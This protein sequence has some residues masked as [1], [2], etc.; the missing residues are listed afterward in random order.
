MLQALLWMVVTVV[1]G[2]GLHSLAYFV[3]HRRSEKVAPPNVSGRVVMYGLF[4]VIGMGFGLFGWNIAVS[5][6]DEA[7]DWPTTAGVITV[8]QAEEEGIVYDRG[9]SFSG[10]VTDPLY[11]V[12]LNYEYSVD[13]TTYTG[14]KILAEEQLTDGKLQLEKAELDDYRE[15]YPV[16][17]QVSVLYDPDEPS[18]SALETSDN[19]APAIMGTSAGVLFSLIGG[20]F[21]FPIAQYLFSRSDQGEEITSSE[22]DY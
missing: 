11:P 10:D 5:A 9:F 13:G 8:F 2:F 6:K 21:S 16:G 1:A 7:A 12:N 17:K 22:E 20:V 3:R 14:D 15:K 4:V 18:Q 19:T